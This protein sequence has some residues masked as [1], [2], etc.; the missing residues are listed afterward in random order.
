MRRKLRTLSLSR[1]RKHPQKSPWREP[2]TGRIH[3][4]CLR[5]FVTAALGHS[6]EEWKRKRLPWTPGQQPWPWESKL[7]HGL[8]IQC[9]FDG[10]AFI[11][12]VLDVVAP[13]SLK[14]DKRSAINSS[15]LEAFRDSR[16]IS[17]SGTGEV[18][19]KAGG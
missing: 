6:V 19:A 5:K 11:L 9:F 7:R 4:C 18:G 15:R 2:H 14:G 17:C 8:L 10:Q 16:S 12:L 3:F 1:G 13:G